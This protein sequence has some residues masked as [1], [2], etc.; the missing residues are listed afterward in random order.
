[1]RLPVRRLREPIQEIPRVTEVPPHRE[2]VAAVVDIGSWQACPRVGLVALRDRLTGHVVAVDPAAL[3]GVARRHDPAIGPKIRPLRT[4][5]TWARVAAPRQCAGSA[6]VQELVTLPFPFY[7][8]R[9]QELREPCGWSPVQ[10][11]L[12]HVLG[13]EA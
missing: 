3:A 2:R 8:E 9:L 7:R 11:A 1:M 4:A 13:R 6:S 10:N 5:G 12:D